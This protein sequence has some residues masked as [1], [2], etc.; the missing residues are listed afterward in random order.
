MKKNILF[1]GFNKKYHNPNF[2]VTLES[3]SSFLNFSYYGPGYSDFSDLEIGINKWVENQKESFDYIITDTF[4][5]EYE[6]IITRPN[7]FNGT[8]TYFKE[9]EYDKW[10]SKL[11]EYFIKSKMTK[12]LIAN[13][14][15][16]NI[17]ITKINEIKLNKIFIIGTDMSL[18]GSYKNVI[19]NYKH[20]NN[21]FK[22]VNDY[23]QFIISSPHFVSYG[24]INR[25][26]LSNR[27][28]NLFVPGTTYKNRKEAINKL[29][30]KRK[31]I[32]WINKLNKYLYYFIMRNPTRNIMDYFNFN[33]NNLI[34]E[35]KYCFTDGSEFKYPVRK[36]F[37]IPSKSTVLICIPFFG[38]EKLGFKHNH[39]CIMIN[40]II[41]LPE[42][43]NNMNDDLAQKIADNGR[44][45]VEEKHSVKSR[46]KQWKSSFKLIENEG[47]KG[48]TWIDGNYV[49]L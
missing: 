22:F 1:V 13:W 3:L 36:Y 20:T 19:T 6:N 11:K 26:K 38:M 23:P 47:F 39:N 4:V 34:S 15:Y 41:E 48:S 43:I 16:Y 5:F 45:F 42:I 17:S 2:S 37:E 25:T 30:L 8:V 21:W 27:K 29:K 49:N 24:E 10:A 40:D 14:D 33:Y 32:Y 28:Y 7:R 35:T 44:E 46:I 9:K 18:M 31:K 12:F